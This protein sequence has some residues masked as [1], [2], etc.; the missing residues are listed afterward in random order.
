MAIDYSWE[1]LYVDAN[2]GDNQQVASNGKSRG[3]NNGDGNFDDWDY[4]YWKFMTQEEY[5]AYVITLSETA[6]VAPVATDGSVKVVLNRTLSANDTWNTIC[7]PF[8]LSE[9]RITAIFG[10]NTVVK[11]LTGATRSGENA[12]LTFGAVSEIAANTPYILKTDQAKSEFKLRGI[13]LT[14]SENLTQTVSGVQFIG[15]YVNPKVLS[16]TSGTDFYIKDNKFYSSPG[17]TKLK[18]FRAYFHVPNGGGSNSVKA[19]F[20]NFDDNATYIQLLNDDCQPT[21]VY[22]VSGILV[23]SGATSLEGLPRGTYITGGKKVQIK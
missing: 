10:D 21:D 22:T 1:Y 8:A 4:G 13:T 6:S 14:P 12:E 20:S 16:N 7:L 3:D 19:L 15:N 18:G 2:T 5:D 17:G 11:E 9:G 23:R